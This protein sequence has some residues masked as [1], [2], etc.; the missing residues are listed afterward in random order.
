MFSSGVRGVDSTV[1]FALLN[2]AL[3]SQRVLGLHIDNGLMRQDESSAVI[4]YMRSHGFDNL[5]VFDASTDFI[6]A[7]KNVWEPEKKG[8]LSAT[9]F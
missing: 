1:A 3:G 5:R 6:D 8:L 2:K 7:L 4:A 9:C